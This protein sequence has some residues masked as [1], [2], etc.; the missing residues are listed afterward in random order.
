MAPRFL[1]SAFASGP[2]LLILIVAT[3]AFV[4][5]A[6]ARV[7]AGGMALTDKQ[8]SFYGEIKVVE[9]FCG[10]SKQRK[11][12]KYLSRMKKNHYN[13]NNEYN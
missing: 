8:P 7:H 5:G 1:G 6:G 3:A 12:R 11:F 2:A 13:T 9:A 10:L 4:P